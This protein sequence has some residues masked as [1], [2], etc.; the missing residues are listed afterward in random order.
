MRVLIIFV[1]ILACVAGVGIYRGWF[2]VTSDRGADKSDVTLTVDKDKIHEDKEKA[3]GKVQGLGHQ[4][5]GQAVAS[6]QP[7]KN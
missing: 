4:A 1:L 5:E 3:V 7:A 2:H 6:T